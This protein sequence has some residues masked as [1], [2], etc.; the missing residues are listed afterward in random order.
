MHTLGDMAKALNRSAVYLHG[1]KARFELPTMAGSGYPEAY[2]KPTTW[3]WVK[4]MVA[5]EILNARYDR[6]DAK[7]QT[8]LGL[9]AS[10]TSSDTCLKSRWPSFSAAS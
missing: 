1:V 3:K 2:L 4:P 8:I 9:F 6:R 5:D 10:N 7:V